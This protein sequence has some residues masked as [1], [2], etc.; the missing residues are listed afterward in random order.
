MDIKVD[1]FKGLYVPN[2][3][4]LGHQDYEVSHFL[5][6]GVGLFKYELT[7]YDDWGNL[8]WKTTEIDEQ[9]RPTQP[10]DGKFNDEYVQQDSYVWKVEAIFKDDSVWI[11]KEYEPTVYKRSGTVTV[12]K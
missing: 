10:W 3:M 9:G 12:I 1:F 6:K 2:A 5:P 11:G 7:I 8:I 4:Y